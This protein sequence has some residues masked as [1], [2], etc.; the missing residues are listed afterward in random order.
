MK[1]LHRFKGRR[2]RTELQIECEGLEEKQERV[3]FRGKQAISGL[4]CPRLNDLGL[5]LW[6]G[7]PLVKSVS[8]LYGGRGMRIARGMVSEWLGRK[9]WECI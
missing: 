2:P 9:W 3:T 7:R 8:I 6:S 5:V 1:S 4:W